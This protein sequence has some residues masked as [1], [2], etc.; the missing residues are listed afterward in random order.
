MYPH[1]RR[2]PFHISD[3]CTERCCFD[4]FSKG[5]LLLE[6]IIQNNN[7]IDINIPMITHVK[8]ICYHI[9][10]FNSLRDCISAVTLPS[11]RYWRVILNRASSCW[12]SC[13]RASRNFDT[14]VLYLPWKSQKFDKQDS[15]AGQT[16][17]ERAEEENVACVEADSFPFPGGAAIAVSEKRERRSTPGVSKKNWGEV[18]LSQFSSRSR[19]FGK[20]KETAAQKAGR[21]RRMGSCDSFTNSC[22]YGFVF[23]F[24]NM[25][26]NCN[27]YINK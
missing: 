10:C 19:A 14:A 18:T 15:K 16:K 7:S 12:K 2:P 23:Y 13:T 11:F 27:K 4:C 20:R 26:R 1:F 17:I 24:A 8:F 22:S 25:P 3:G 21:L 5:R 6:L 9:T